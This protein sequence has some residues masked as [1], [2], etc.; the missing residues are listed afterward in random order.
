MLKVIEMGIHNGKN[1]LSEP[2]VA[3]KPADNQSV[4]PQLQ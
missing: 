2:A 4:G 1:T 3:D